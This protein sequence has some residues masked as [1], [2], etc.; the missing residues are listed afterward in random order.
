MN[1][2]LER[3]YELRELIINKN[4]DSSEIDFLDKIIEHTSATGGLAI[5]G[6]VPLSI[7]VGIGGGATTTGNTNVMT[8]PVQDTPTPFPGA[9][10]GTDWVNSK[11]KAGSGD[12]SVP[13]NPMGKNRV[14][15][16]IPFNNNNKKRGRLQTFTSIDTGKKQKQKV[17][18]FQEFTTKNIDTKVTK[19][20][21]F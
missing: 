19:V 21:D 3:L 9:L 4:Y 17:M 20:R 18:N 13:F 14:F 1:E 8:S 10:N 6:A 15:Q 7:G 11:G 16:K 2:E 5:G 12:I